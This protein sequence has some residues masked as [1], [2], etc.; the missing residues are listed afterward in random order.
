MKVWL[1]T[2]E[3]NAYDQ[4]GEYFE[5]VFHD[6]PT[7]LQ[8]AANGI[9]DPSLQEHILNGGGR[10]GYEDGWYNLKEEELQ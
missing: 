2:S 1:L 5:A 9:S 10:R 6:K 3:C 7:A 8:L 4:F